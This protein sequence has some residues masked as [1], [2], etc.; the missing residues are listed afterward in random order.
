MIYQHL[1]YC[2]LKLLT[3][4]FAFYIWKQ[5]KNFFFFDFTIF[6]LLINIVSIYIYILIISYSNIERENNKIELIL[7]KIMIAT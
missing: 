6:F 5:K 2:F 1:K 4:K 7:L 3:K